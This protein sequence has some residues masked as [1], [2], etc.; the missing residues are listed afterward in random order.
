MR[1]YEEIKTSGLRN[2]LSDDEEIMFSVMKGAEEIIAGGEEL[3]LVTMYD[4]CDDVME[5]YNACFTESGVYSAGGDNWF[6]KCIY[7]NRDKGIRYEITIMPAGY[8]VTD[9]NV[10]LLYTEMSD[11]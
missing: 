4:V 11:E 5:E 9:V 2:G 10:S 7:E 6:S 3:T 8:T 1:S